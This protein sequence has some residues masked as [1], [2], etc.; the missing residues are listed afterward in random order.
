MVW[1][2]ALNGY[3][4]LVSGIF[5][6]CMGFFVFFKSPTKKLNIV[7]LL[8]TASMANWLIVS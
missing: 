7:Y 6:L 8:F 5:M 4:A 3:T 1:L 2:S